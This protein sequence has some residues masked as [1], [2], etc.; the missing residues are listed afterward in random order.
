[1]RTV[2]SNFK[3]KIGRSLIHDLT[4]CIAL[5]IGQKYNV[6]EKSSVVAGHLTLMSPAINMHCNFKLSIIYIYIY[7]I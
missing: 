7:Y 3:T 2:I 4:Q 5:I 6:E 1:M